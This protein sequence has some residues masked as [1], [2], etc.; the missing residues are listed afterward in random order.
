MDDQ[1][2]PTD[3][4]PSLESVKAFFYQNGYPPL[5]ATKF[6]NHF[7]SNGWKVSGKTPMQNWQASSMNWM[8]RAVNF[9]FDAKNSANAGKDTTPAG[10]LHTDVGKD[11]AQ[12]L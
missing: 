7:S 5:E 2:H 9:S 4:P 6:Y 11:Y 10:R 8:Y 1:S 3:I 12:P